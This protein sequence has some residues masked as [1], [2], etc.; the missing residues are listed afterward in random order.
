[1]ENKRAGRDEVDSDDSDGNAT[2]EDSESDDEDDEEAE[3]T[4]R[5][6][7]RRQYRYS[8]RSC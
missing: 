1:M 3:M 5:A 8:K 7:T 2:S 6:G 4:R